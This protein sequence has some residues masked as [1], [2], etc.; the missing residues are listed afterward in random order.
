MT[1]TGTN[2]KTIKK[3]EQCH[4][5]TISDTAGYEAGNIAGSAESGLK[6]KEQ[7]TRFVA[8]KV[9]FIFFLLALLLV[10]FGVSAS[11]GSAGISIWDAYSAVLWKFFPDYFHP[12]EL[13]RIVIWKLR[14]PRLLMG[15]AAGFGL[16]VTGSVMQGI[17]KNPLASPYTFGIS[18]AAGFGAALAILFGIGFTGGIVVNA[19]VFALAASAI[20][21]ALGRYKGAKPETMVLAGIAIMYLFSALTS[22]LQYFG[23]ADAVKEVVFWMMGDLDKAAW[24]KLT[25]MLSTLVCCIPLLIIKSWDLNVMGAGDEAA[26]SIGVRVEH[27]RILTMTIASLITASIVCFTGAIGFIGLVAPH[28]TR[29]IVGGDYRF[30]L[31]A[32]GVLGAVLLLSADIVA[33]TIIAPVI[34]PVGVMTALLGVPFFFYLIVRK[35]RSYF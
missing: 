27:V 19:F 5:N 31:P 15:I 29:M 4:C 24:N 33:R 18:A 14:L 3:A 6:I 13:A 26:K 35:R 28:I 21:I 22:L 1:V 8:R 2:K 7:Y 11:I 12:S 34:I 17:L 32:S 10:V 16:A 23:D 20:I 9:V 25:V 30:L